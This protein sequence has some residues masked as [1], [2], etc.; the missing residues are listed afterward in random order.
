MT[1]SRRALFRWRKLK[2]WRNEDANKENETIECN[3]NI[4]ESDE[5]SNEKQAKEKAKTKKLFMMK[6]VVV[7]NLIY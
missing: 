1:K 6:V 3:E 7:N 2:I 5:K 4:D